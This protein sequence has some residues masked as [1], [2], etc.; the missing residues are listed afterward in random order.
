MGQ[1]SEDM[2]RKKFVI[3]IGS[4][5]GLVGIYLAKYFRKRFDSSIYL[6][7]LDSSNLIY[8]KH[9]VNEFHLAPPH[10]LLPELQS[11]NSAQ[12]LHKL[13]IAM[14]GEAIV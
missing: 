10:P 14:T 5:G 4:C 1:L 6:I 3:V 7:G 9:I 13:K 12:S 2:I 8:T 11:V